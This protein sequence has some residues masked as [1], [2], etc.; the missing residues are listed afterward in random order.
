MIEYSQIVVYFIHEIKI[1]YLG[2]RFEKWMIK[3]WKSM[4]GY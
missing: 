4:D 1:E 2:E 3:C